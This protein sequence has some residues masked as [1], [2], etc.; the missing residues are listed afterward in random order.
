MTQG[1]TGSPRMPGLGL[2]HA[3]GLVMAVGASL[4]FATARAGILGGLAP[5]D[6]IFA[7]FL[8]A[9]LVMLPFLL[10]WGLPDLAGI[11][12]RR[13]CILALTGGPLFAI[14][15]T[16]GYAFAP[17]AH[18]AVIAPSTVTIVSTI[19]AGLFLGE[20]LTR[21]HLS[22]A[23]LVLAGILLIGWHGIA[24]DNGMPASWIGDLMFGASSLLW[25]TFTLLLRA[26]RV[27]AARA[28]AV[29][30]VMSCVLASP[31]YLA[32]RGIDHLAA[33]PVGPIV[34]QGLT[35]GLIQGVI[36]IMAYSKAVALLGVSR[37]VLFPAIVPAVSVLIGIPL[38]GEIPDAVQIA[39]IL[40]VSV[41]LLIA[42]GVLGLPATPSRAA[43]GGAP[44]LSPPASLHNPAPKPAGP[45]EETP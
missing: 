15:Q 16:G 7:R 35:Q 9:G 17:L 34:V 8:V 43:T 11:G 38:V 12:W 22:G 5:D 30:S 37:A 24:A 2:G 36:T 21:A 27:E 4:A 29:V 14:L 25:A 44:P 40:T 3:C 10:H 41:G 28:T 42:V 26:W 18:G 23:A 32:V 45:S 33:L 20:R 39:G 31:I 1:P 6:L 19:A 13:G